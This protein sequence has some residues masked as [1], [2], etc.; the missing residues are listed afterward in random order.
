MNTARVPACLLAILA[1]VTG[2]SAQTADNPLLELGKPVEREL[3]AGQVHSYSIELSAGQYLRLHA[4]QRGIDIVLALFGPAGEKRLEIDGMTGVQGSEEIWLVVETAGRYR[5]DVR[6][7]VKTASGKY[8]IRIQELR[9]AT[10]RDRKRVAAE[11]AFQ[12]AQKFQAERTQASHLKAI[13]KFSEALTLWRAI[14]DRQ[15]EGTTLNNIGFAYEQLGER[16]KALKA[17]DEALQAYRAAKYPYGEGFALENAGRILKYIGQVPKALDYYNSALNAF[18]ASGDELRVGIALGNIGLIHSES[19]ENQKAVEHYEQALKLFRGR[20]RPQEESNS[21][22][23]LGRHYDLVGDKQRALEYYQQALAITRQLKSA[24]RQAV[25]LNLIGLLYDSIGESQQALDAFRESLPLFRTAKD[26][27]G[28]GN[29]I[30]NLGLAYSALGEQER[31]LDSYQQALPIWRAIVD[32]RREAVTLHNIGMI[33]LGRG[34]TEKALEHFTQALPLSGGVKDRRM[35]ATTLDGI[36]EVHLARGDG[37]RAI[38]QFNQALAIRRETDDRRGEGSTLANLGK[39]YAALGDPDKAL[40]HHEQAL[41]VRRAVRDQRGEA[42]SAFELARVEQRRGNLDTARRHIDSAIELAESLRTKVAGQDLRASFLASVQDYYALNIDVLMRLHSRN[43]GAGFDALAF[44]MS[45]RARARG[46]LETL[47]EARAGIREG[48]DPA[49]LERERSL[50]R[51]LNGKEQMRI[52]LLARKHTPEQAA[53]AAKELNDIA[54]Q[55]QEVQTEIRMKSPRYAALTQL[56]PLTVAEIQREVLDENTILLE[57]AMG[58]ERGYVWAL[59]RNSIAGFELPPREQIESV[60]RRFYGALVAMSPSADAAT[61]ARPNVDLKQ[62][63]GELSRML[64]APVAERLVGAKRVVVVSSGVLQYVPFAALSSGASAAPLI[65]S[66]EVISLPSASTAGILRR[67]PARIQPAPKLLALFADPVFAADDPRI[68][69]AQA[70]GPAGAEARLT[71]EMEDDSLTRSANESGLM[72]RGQRIPR[73]PGTRREAAAITGLVPEAERKV[74]LDFEASRAAVA[75]GDIDQYRIVHIATHGLLNSTHP[76]LSGIVLSLVDS[77]GQPRDGFLRLHE[78]YNLKLSADL[79]VLSAC[80][81]GLGKDIK[82]EGLV[83]LTRGF[84]YAG[85]SRVMASLWNVDDRA[86]AEL[87]SRFYRG[88]IKDGLR[89]AAAL[90]AAQLAMLQQKQWAEPYYWAAFVVQGDWK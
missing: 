59:S 15:E 26:R 6:P 83:G 54:A 10:D 1:L 31:A 47:A 53:A 21:L 45:E 69:R 43:P 84:M 86:T 56:R 65:A 4:E 55:Y 35:E 51:Q 61:N 90:R 80:Q 81:T 34:E 49:L 24:Q 52:E 32:P 7:L 66:H 75:E 33:H 5:V 67:D 25:V 40:A 88:M 23:H 71:R 57:Y 38:E 78:I 36:G 70:L 89:P 22:T 79:V 37:P 87:M 12:Q 29:V 60:A 63:G 20:H 39:A 48:V 50:Q 16:E 64:L 19:G 58:N 82:G 44:Q 77:D 46:L 28:E 30:N 74:A 3:T 41:A 27:R 76:E 73:L 18:R 2:A 13:E 17:Y 85:A 14:D 9:E 62:V 68:K 11:I 72:Q 42:A 8:E